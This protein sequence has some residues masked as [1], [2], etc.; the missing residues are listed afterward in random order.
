MSRPRASIAHLELRGVQH[1]KIVSHINDKKLSLANREELEKVFTDLKRSYAL[2]AADV[3]L[4]GEVL[5]VVRYSSK[6]VPF[7]AE[8]YNPYWK[9][10]TKAATSMAAIAKLLSQFDEPKKN[11]VTRPGSARDLM[12][13]LFR[14]EP[15]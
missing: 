10:M 3:N 4:R 6:G 12:P 1:S 5:T 7:E 14:K 8:V 13:A 15:S 2:A 9:V 11:I